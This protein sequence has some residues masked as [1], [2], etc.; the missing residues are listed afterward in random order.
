[1]ALQPVKILVLAS[2]GF[3]Y[4][5]TAP[6]VEDIRTI[7]YYSYT[8]HLGEEK[9]TTTLNAVLNFNSPGVSS[10]SIA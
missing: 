7:L 3:R 1:M 8:E 9:K 10:E 6:N 4:H 5:R 2:V